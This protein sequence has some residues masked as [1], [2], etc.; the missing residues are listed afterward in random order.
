MALSAHNFKPLNLWRGVKTIG[1]YRSDRLRWLL[2]L[3]QQIGD[4]GTYQFGPWEG[5]MANSSEYAHAVLRAPDAERL[6]GLADFAAEVGSRLVAS[7]T[8]AKVAHL[9]RTDPAAL[10]RTALKSQATPE[11]SQGER[12]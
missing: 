5:I 11:P 4:F 10:Q 6:N 7:F 2:E 1:A 12:R 9:A 8:I 3:S